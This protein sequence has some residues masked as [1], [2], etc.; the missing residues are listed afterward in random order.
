M[1][2]KGLI[3]IFFLIVTGIFSWQNWQNITLVFF[4]VNTVSLPLSISILCFIL[5]GFISSLI[6]QLLSKSSANKTN[7]N[8]PDISKSPVSPIYPPAEEY[9]QPEE[10]PRE[11]YVNRRENISTKNLEQIPVIDR[12]DQAKRIQIPLVQEL[13]NQPEMIAETNIDYPEPI[14]KQ[15]EE[16]SEKIKSEDKDMVN[17]HDA[18]DDDLIS[19]AE[20]IKKPRQASPYSY[21]TREKTSIFPKKPST[22]YSNRPRKRRINKEQDGIYTAEYRVIT[23]ANNQPKP[24]FP[25]SNEDEDDWDF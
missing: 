4:G 1:G 16:V 23:P 13:D 3:L 20:S 14:S 15:E 2:V 12:E 6:I 11:K 9:P 5:A 18:T 17:N 8:P 24:D 7:Q 21:T 22:D 19:P 25:Q 10:L